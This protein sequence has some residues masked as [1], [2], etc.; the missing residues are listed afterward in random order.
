MLKYLWFFKTPKKFPWNKTNSPTCH[1]QLVCYE[2]L[3]PIFSKPK[4]AK[5]KGKT[6]MSHSITSLTNITLTML[7]IYSSFITIQ[8][9]MSCVPCRQMQHH[10]Y[11]GSTSLISNSM[12]T[13]EIT[14]N[15]NLQIID[16][17]INISSL[18]CENINYLIMLKETTFSLHDT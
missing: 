16:S 6:W 3:S 1:P 5:C 10:E 4:E 13:N 14:F 17:P 9:N 2:M 11:Y 7:N 15:I 18:P 12:G 8:Q